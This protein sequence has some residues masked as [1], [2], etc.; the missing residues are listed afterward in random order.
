MYVVILL[1]R[2]ELQALTRGDIDWDQPYTFFN[3]VYS[4][5]DENS[6]VQR[7]IGG[8]V[9]AFLNM[10]YVCITDCHSYL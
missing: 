4:V 6:N 3:H 10:W 5:T 9:G 8:T 7:D 1:Y 2:C